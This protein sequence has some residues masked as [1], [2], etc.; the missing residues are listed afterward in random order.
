MSVVSCPLQESPFSKA[1]E[2]WERSGFDPSVVVVFPNHRSCRSF[3]QEIK[4]R[5]ANVV[6]PMIY[7][8]TDLFFCD[9]NVVDII[10]ILVKKYDKVS[11]RAICNLAEE[12]ANT[13]KEIVLNK[14][15]YSVL[16]DK[17]PHLLQPYWENFSDVLQ[18]VAPIIEHSEKI[19]DYQVAEAELLVSRHKIIA[20]ELGRANRCITD[21]LKKIVETSDN[22]IILLSLEAPINH[23]IKLSLLDDNQKCE[24]TSHVVQNHIEQMTFQTVNEEI[25]AVALAVR[26]AISENKSVL[27]I[28]Q[29]RNFTYRLKVQLMRWHVMPDSSLGTPLI[30]TLE[31]KLLILAAEVLLNNFDCNSMINLLKCRKDIVDAVYS[32]EIYRRKLGIAPKNFMKCYSKYKDRD[33]NIQGILEKIGEINTLE[34]RTFYEW[35]NLC[36]ALLNAIFENVDNILQHTDFYRFLLP[37]VTMSIEEFTYLLN[38]KILVQSQQQAKG[39]TGNVAI[40]GIIEAQLLTADL[41]IIPN[42]NTQNLTTQDN[43]IIL[44]KAMRRD[45]QIPTSEQQNDFIASIF[46][47]L[48]NQPNVL[49]TRS[50]RADDGQQLEYP[51][52]RDFAT[53]PSDLG[54]LVAIVMENIP[55]IEKSKKIFPVPNTLPEKISASSVDLLITNPYAFYASNILEL[56]EIPPM[57]ISSIKGNFIHEILHRFVRDKLY[58]EK[59]L[60]REV[61]KIMQENKLQIS[62]VGVCYF[63]LSDLFAFLL[64]NF[65][66]AKS[67]F[68]EISGKFNLRLS[69]ETEITL[70]CR[71]DCLEVSREGHCTIIDY[72]TYDP[73]TAKEIE[74]L[75]KLQLPVEAIIALHGGFNTNIKNVVSLQYWRVPNALE[76]KEVVKS[77]KVEEICKKTI[78]VLKNSL[79]K[80]RSYELKP[81]DIRNAC[82]KHL[83]R[84][85]EWAND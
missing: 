40:V 58:S 76:I 77:D 70:Q 82:Y 83:S 1:F 72:K 80:S 54:K 17:I 60:W 50:V 8:I 33:A 3:K 21:F 29:S 65:D 75:K 41:V 79:N 16:R 23:R 59:A 53:C 38:S 35:S 19:R 52:L 37:H 39:Y 36:Y 78:E 74:S 2:F 11:L 69:D 73:P 25:F 22:T 61:E 20:V 6:F 9:V 62:D 55:T 12:V 26:R 85:K 27:V 5:Q 45:L 42:V 63:Q 47:R 48:M 81:S 46:E 28:T 13:I 51:L 10:N 7:S 71:A 14:V 57:F 67:H 66:C 24:G 32:F 31:G 49:V 43:N 56:K 4:K 34:R 64:R 18:L 84:Y 44:T 15:D 30:D 68:S